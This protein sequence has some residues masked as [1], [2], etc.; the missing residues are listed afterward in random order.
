M[1]KLS[2]RQKY[3][4]S[5]VIAVPILFFASYLALGGESSYSILLDIM[6]Y[7]G[8]YVAGLIYQ[9]EIDIQ[10]LPLYPLSKLEKML[11]RIKRICLGMLYS[12][13][14]YQLFANFFHR[15]N[16][17]DFERLVVSLLILFTLQEVF[18]YQIQSAKKL[19]VIHIILCGFV[20]FLSFIIPNILQ[21]TIVSLFILGFCI[22]W[23]YHQSA[24]RKS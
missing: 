2:L 6:P 1:K 14:W 13:I 9:S 12:V 8:A 5:E 7:G 24:R 22:F 23:M 19:I 10:L 4:L 17:D 15:F 21:F 11:P 20:V 16:I 18:S 3:F